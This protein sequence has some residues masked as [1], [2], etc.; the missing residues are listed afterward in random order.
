MVDFPSSLIS[1]AA[2]FGLAGWRES[3]LEDRKGLQLLPVMGI[4]RR[5][6]ENFDIL[7]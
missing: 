6:C 5:E 2:M 1:F 4:S 3:G 7:T